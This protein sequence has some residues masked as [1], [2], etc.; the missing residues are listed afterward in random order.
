[1][2]FII[3]FIIL[4]L[5]I[6]HYKSFTYWDRRNIKHD[7]PLPIFGNHIKNIFG[8][9][10]EIEMGM[11][12]YRKFPNERLVGYYRCK[13]PVLIIRDPDLV[14]HILVN[15]YVSFYGR[16]LGRDHE[17]MLMLNLFHS[18]GDLWQLL[19]H[20]ISPTFTSAK[21]RAMFPLI[22]KCTVRLHAVAQELSERGN[23]ISAHELMARYTMEFIGSCGF[24]INMNTLNTDKSLFI[25]LGQIIFTKT[26]WQVFFLALREFLSKDSFIKKISVARNEII[27]S[28]MNLMDIIRK[29]RNEKNIQRNDFVDILLKLEKEKVI[30]DHS[31]LNK[32]E[33]G[34][35]VKIKLN[36]TEM[37]TAAQLF[38]F[39]AGGFETSATTMSWTLHQLSYHPDVQRK[40]QEELDKTLQK[41]NGICYDAIMELPYLHM[42]IKEAIRTFTPAGYISRECMKKYVIPG[43]NIT[44][45]PGVLIN[46]PAQAIHLDPHNFDNPDEFRPERFTAEEESKRHKYAFLPFG[47]GPRK[48]IGSRLGL[49]ETMSG[50]ATILQHFTVYPGPSSKRTFKVKR[51]AFIIQALDE[52][53]PILLKPRKK[54][55]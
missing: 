18:Q 29:E 11:E 1:M 9:R 46:I 6:W 4:I 27:T 7:F 33:N 40:V 37:H 8:L 3:I 51:N 53:I 5:L 45:D 24:G 10:T 54:T 55:L 47:G 17:E 38:I 22:Q 48:C 42:T 36:Y 15:D 32:D 30:E 2:I 39:F 14:K 44:I 50:L 19:R 21:L 26:K 41:Y 16:G 12:M 43:T 31:I 25:E 34:V 49:I 35:P 20:A 52:D 13:T 23:E 28:I